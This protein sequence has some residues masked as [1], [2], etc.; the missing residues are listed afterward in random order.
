MEEEA[1]MEVDT[2]EV[3]MEVVI[4]EEDIMG[5]VITGVVITEGTTEDTMGEHLILIIMDII[6]ICMTEML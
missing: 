4:T 2:G 3:T 1:I 5:E 6:T